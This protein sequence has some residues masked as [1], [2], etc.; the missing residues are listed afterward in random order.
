[1]VECTYWC[2]N[3]SWSFCNNFGLC[4]RT[5]GP[6]VLYDYTKNNI[7]KLYIVSMRFLYVWIRV[8]FYIRDRK[9]HQDVWTFSRFRRCVKFYWFEYSADERFP[10]NHPGWY[11][12][13][14][15]PTTRAPAGGSFEYCEFLLSAG[16]NIQE[17]F[18]FSVKVGCRQ[19]KWLGSP[20]RTL[21]SPSIRRGEWHGKSARWYWSTYS[22]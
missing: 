5:V 3:S 1:M 11:L 16:T 2:L 7:Q 21:H 6:Y 18:S 17:K 12:D 19:Y 9:T 14:T 8:Y 20:T 15:M 4:R 10:I 13:S 22:P